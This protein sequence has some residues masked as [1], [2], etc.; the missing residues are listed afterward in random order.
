MEASMTTL[1]IAPMIVIKPVAITAGFELLN[2][3]LAS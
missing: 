3:G 2:D 1:S